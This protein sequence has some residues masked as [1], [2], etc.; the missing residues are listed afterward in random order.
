MRERKAGI[1]PPVLAAPE[2]PKNVF[3]EI[4]GTFDSEW[5]GEKDEEKIKRKMLELTKELFREKSSSKREEIKRQITVLKNMLAVPAEPKKGKVAKEEK[6][7]SGLFSA[8]SGAMDSEFASKISAFSSGAEKQI[9]AAKERF[10][11]SLVDIPE[12]D[13]GARKGVLDKLMFELTGIGEQV[14]AKSGA[15]I[16]EILEKHIDMISQFEQS[17][18]EKD[19]VS[20]D[21]ADEKKEGLKAKYEKE[22]EL[23][24]TSIHTR[25]NAII[26]ESSRGL[27]VSERKET[28]KEKGKEEAS[29]I[30]NEIAEIDEGSLLFYL[31]AQDLNAYKSFEHKRISRQEAVNLARRIMAKEKGLNEEVINKHWGE[32]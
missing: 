16:E 22:M 30:I 26:E 6:Y 29:N 11:N 12:D 9:S 1:V 2:E 5:S 23:L 15:F 31:H 17:L 27:I 24:K 14:D 20:A 13:A 21:K 25:I 4:K 8:V 32:I 28:K 10:K 3:E 18:T 19:K 7:S